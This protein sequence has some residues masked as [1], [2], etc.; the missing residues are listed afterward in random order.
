[1]HTLVC[2]IK[3]GVH[4]RGSLDAL[5]YGSWCCISLFVRVRYDP[6]PIG[7]GVLL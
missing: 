5:L 4:D 2:R 7:K 3:G 1:M 6:N